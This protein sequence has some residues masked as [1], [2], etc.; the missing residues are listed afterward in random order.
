MKHICIDQ[1]QFFIGQEVGVSDWVC[2]SQ[3]Q[4]NLFA[5]S[6]HDHQWIHVDQDRAALELECGTTIAHGYLV[7]S[8]IPYFKQMILTIDDLSRSLNYGMNRVRF[9]SPVSTGSRIRGRQKILSA[10]MRSDG[11]LLCTSEMAIEVEGRTLPACVAEIINVF[12]R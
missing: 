3:A 1:I 7:L 11:G 4:V 5:D 9:I 2:I 12:Y 10:A 8:M 6:T